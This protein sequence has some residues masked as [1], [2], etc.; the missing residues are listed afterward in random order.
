MRDFPVDEDLVAL[1]WERAKPQPFEQLSFN[2]A[3][4]RVLGAHLHSPLLK[5]KAG[6]AAIDTDALLR[7]LEASPTKGPRQRARKADL[8]KLIRLGR[9]HEGQELFFIDYR[10]QRRNDC[11]AN[12]SG[13]DLSYKGKLYSMSALAGQLLKKEGYVG[14]AVRGP[15]HWATSDGTSVSD[16][17]RSVLSAAGT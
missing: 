13:G 12:I 15:E 16:L 4:R 10:G 5:F 7:E 6:S 9:L 3:L 17:W 14:D 11:K 2:D 1:I 8:R